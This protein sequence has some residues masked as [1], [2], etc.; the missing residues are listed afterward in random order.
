MVIKE[1]VKNQFNLEGKVALVT[2]ATGALG[3]AAAWGY[4]YAGAKVMLTART[5]TKL[6]ALYEQMVAEGIQCAY[7]IGDPTN[8]AQVESVVAAT[9]EEFG[10]IDILM[11][12]A[13]MNNPKPILEQP[14]EEWEAIMDANVKGTWLY[15]KKAGQVMKEQGLGGKVILVSSTRGKLGM[16]GYTAYS[17]SKAAIDLMA[18]SL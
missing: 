13:G 14:T 7:R 4:G 18:K 9:V 10:G 5:E 11:C 16:K 8:E 2:G 3:S 1:E 12:S 6:R 17:P 15:C